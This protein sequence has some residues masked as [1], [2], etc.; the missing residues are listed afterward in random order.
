MLCFEVTLQ[1]D[2]EICGGE[3]VEELLRVL[4]QLAFHSCGHCEL[5]WAT[6][7]HVASHVWLQENK[8]YTRSFHSVSDQVGREAFK[9]Y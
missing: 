9:P 8:L 7:S 1:L 4:Q 3:E 2:F 5:I 6:A